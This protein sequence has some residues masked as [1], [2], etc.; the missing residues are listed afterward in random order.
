MGRSN[1]VRGL[2]PVRRNERK[3]AEEA[4]RIVAARERTLLM[5]GR[6]VW[7]DATTRIAS[8]RFADAITLP[9]TLGNWTY[10]QRLKLISHASM[11]TLLRTLE[12]KR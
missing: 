1:A 5:F 10:S 9:M 8:S 11:L 6:E 7:E 4:A 2:G 12:R 3:F